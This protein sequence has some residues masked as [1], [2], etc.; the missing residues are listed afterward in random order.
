M[1]NPI[2]SMEIQVKQDNF[3]T[4]YCQLLRATD[5]RIVEGSAEISNFIYN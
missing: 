2:S 4:S 5:S 3:S 1:S